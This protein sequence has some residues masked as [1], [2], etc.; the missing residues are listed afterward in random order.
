MNKSA[1]KIIE[2]IKNEIHYIDF[3]DKSKNNK[4]DFTR[5][6]KLPFTALILFMLNSVKGTIQ[7]KFDSLLI[8]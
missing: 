8:I 7:P 3:M 6:R 2:V 4:N 5:N 1:F